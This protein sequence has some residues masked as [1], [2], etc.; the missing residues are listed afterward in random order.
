MGDSRIK[1]ILMHYGEEH[2]AV[3]AIE[4]LGELIIAIARGDAE[5][6]EEE[7]ADSMILIEQLLEFKEINRLN[8]MQIK[9]SKIRRTL[10]RA[11]KEKLAK[12]LKRKRRIEL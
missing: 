4:E 2:Q 5:N 10:E 1:E 9:E 3:K 11:N 7:I 8:V 12:F 6:I